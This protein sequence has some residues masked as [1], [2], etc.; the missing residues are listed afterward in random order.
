M[1]KQVIDMFW[2]NNKKPTDLG[3]LSIVGV[4]EPKVLLPQYFYANKNIGMK[5][6]EKY[7]IKIWL[8]NLSYK[9]K[10]YVKYILN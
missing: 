7:V 5:I 3:W 10:G 8:I 1:A 6:S 4:E 2:K 9:M